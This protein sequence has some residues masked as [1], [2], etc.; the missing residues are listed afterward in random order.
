[1]AHA[2]PSVRHTAPQQWLTGLG[3]RPA[4]AR[5]LRPWARNALHQA[6]CP[7]ACLA[8]CTHGPQLA[9]PSAVR[10]ARPDPQLPARPP[11]RMPA[12]SGCSLGVSAC[13][14]AAAC[15]E[16]ARSSATA[17]PPLK[18]VPRQASCPGADATLALPTRR[19][20]L[21]TPSCSRPSAA[22][23]DHGARRRLAPHAAAT[24]AGGTA[25]LWF[26]PAPRLPPHTLC[27][28][29]PPPRVRE[30]RRPADYFA[31][32]G[33]PLALHASCEPALYTNSMT[34]ISVASPRRSTGSVLTRV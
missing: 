33:L 6:C 29:P 10:S 31:P 25:V 18:P 11:A 3:H 8:G 23:F 28:Q 2:P 14:L 21:A 7:P 4:P 30:A 34:A 15:R 16:A 20:L 12:C 13:P 32:A 27:A 26:R 24:L 9:A 19:E 17:A 22:S 5:P 1:M